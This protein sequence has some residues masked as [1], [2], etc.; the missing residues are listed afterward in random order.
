VTAS[1]VLSSIAGIHHMNN[2]TWWIPAMDDSTNGA[3]IHCG[4]SPCSFD[5]CETVPLSGRLLLDQDNWL[6]PQ[7]RLYAAGVHDHHRRLLLISP[8]A[9]TTEDR[10]LNRLRQ[11]SV[12][13]Q[14]LANFVYITEAFAINTQPFVVGFDP[15]RA[16]SCWITAILSWLSF[17]KR[18]L[19]FEHTSCVA[20]AVCVHGWSA[21]PLLVLRISDLLDEEKRCRQTCSHIRSLSGVDCSCYMSSALYTVVHKKVPLLFL[22]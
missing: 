10:R 3:V 8:K 4:N 21:Q 2:W 13:V 7:V 22:L 6:G 9:G 1:M 16:R 17:Y 12:G 20:G 18:L 5:E 14:P 19:I 15:C 11:C